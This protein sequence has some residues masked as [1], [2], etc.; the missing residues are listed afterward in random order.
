M[1]FS[2]GKKKRKSP[3][4]VKKGVKK[5][6]NRKP[7]A[8]LI[9]A[10][11]KLHIKVTKKVGKHRVYKK[12]SVLKKLLKRKLKRTKKTVKRVKKHSV[13]RK[14]RFG[15]A[16][17]FTQ[18]SDYGYNQTVKSALG[19]LSQSSQ[20]ATPASNIN[21]PPG[22]GLEAGNLPIYG[23]YRPFFT[24][25]VPTMVGPNS[26]GFM[27]QPDG[28]LYPVGG[29]FSRYTSFG[30]K[31]KGG[32][33]ARFGNGG[34]PPLMKTAGGR[35]CS[36]NTGILGMNTTGLFPTSCTNTGSSPASAF[37]KRRKARFG[38]IRSRLFGRQ[39]RYA[40]RGGENGRG[41]SDEK[42][43]KIYAQRNPNLYTR[44][45]PGPM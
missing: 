29:P 23:V 35:F 32:R 36:N 13:K 15:N 22:F 16:A 25:Q 24:E 4:K 18:P 12:V 28:S 9:K 26:I 31:R 19:S 33:K 5:V 17:A 43:K 44:N 40:S 34:N 1:F 11:K 42:C 30:K 6:V 45:C 39:D 8:L 14:F 27:G 2:F 3:K 37:G 7:P 20:V 10:C 41:E 21:R 38:F